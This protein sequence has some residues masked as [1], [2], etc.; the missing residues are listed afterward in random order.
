MHLDSGQSQEIGRDQNPGFFVDG[1][2]A[3]RS[4]LGILK[5]AGDWMFPQEIR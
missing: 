1:D 4:Q 2:T 3:L 5:R